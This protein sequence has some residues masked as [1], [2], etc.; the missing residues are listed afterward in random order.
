MWNSFVSPFLFTVSLWFYYQYDSCISSLLSNS[1][2]HCRIRFRLF[3]SFFLQSESERPLQ[4][5]LSDENCYLRAKICRKS[6]LHSSVGPF[7]GFILGFIVVGINK[8]I[9]GWNWEFTHFLDAKSDRRARQSLFIRNNKK[10]N[11][12]QLQA[13][14]SALHANVYVRRAVIKCKFVGLML[15]LLAVSVAWNFVLL[16]L[17]KKNMKRCIICSTK[18]MKHPSKLATESEN[19]SFLF[20]N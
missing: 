7:L 3:V 15:S 19:L 17:E 8:Q 6:N 4:L 2:E 5:F 14:S 20:N 1:I 12:M 16:P 18:N 13:I 10:M 9:K 11:R